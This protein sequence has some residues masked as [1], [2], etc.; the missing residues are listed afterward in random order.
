MKSIKS[1]KRTYRIISDNAVR[2]R[3]MTITAVCLAFYA[4]FAF[5]CN[6]YLPLPF[7]ANF[8]N[9]DISLVFLIP[10]VFICPIKWW[11]SSSLISGFFNFLW[12]SSGGWVG[13]LFNVIVN[14][15]TLLVFYFLNIFLLERKK[16]KKHFVF[17]LILSLI[18][19]LVVLVLFN[20]FINGIFFT[21]LYWWSFGIITSP[22]FLFAQQAYESY[23]SLKVWLLFIPNY[24]DGIM[25]LYSIFNSL[26]FGITFVLLF[27]L[28]IVIFKS[29]IVNHF[30]S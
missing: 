1:K 25:T 21:P 6:T 3:S 18:I 23:D 26:K 4:I 19:A 16:N 9:L 20:C 10:L 8:L 14:F 7:L 24:W 27:P 28:L 15:T 5:F 29:K 11:I 2:L 30:Y 22:S 13:A 17:Y 12:A